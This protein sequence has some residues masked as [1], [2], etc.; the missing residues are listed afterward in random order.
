M[1]RFEIRRQSCLVAVPIFDRAVFSFQKSEQAA[2]RAVPELMAPCFDRVA[3]FD[4]VAGDPDFFK[5]GAAG[6]FQSPDLRLA[7]G[8]LYFQVDPRMR[9][10]QVQFLD[11]AL[12]INE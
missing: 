5:S 6:G 11:D 2:I 8:I 1:A 12:Q 3:W 9:D 10:H 7:L 4:G